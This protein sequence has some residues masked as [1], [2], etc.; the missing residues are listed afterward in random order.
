MNYALIIVLIPALSFWIG[1]L[2]NKIFKNSKKLTNYSIALAFSI[3]IGLFFIDFIPHY[4]HLFEGL[5]PFRKLLNVTF[6]MIVG[7]AI[8]KVIDLIIPHHHHENS[9]E[10]LYHIGLVTSMSL[11]L[12]NIIEGISVYNIA[13]SSISS[14]LLLA[15]AVSLHNIPLSIS[16][17]N[18]LSTSKQSK[19]TKYVI[20]ALL[21]IS[22]IFGASLISAYN[23]EFNHNIEGIILSITFGMIIYLI[24]FE[25]SKKVIKN[26]K[27][28]EVLYGL[29][30]GIVII[31]ISSL[32]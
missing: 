28:K 16:I 24:I 2:V 9:K 20:I 21:S 27:T 14:G 30:T 3:M 32:I 26:I 5:T 4:D 23:L 11:I 19:K 6:Y 12:H 22:T 25:L 17:F 29:M 7:F 15:L 31:I 10:H 8:L 13:L 18:N 1:V